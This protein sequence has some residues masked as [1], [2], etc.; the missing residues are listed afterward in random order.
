MLISSGQA[1][2]WVLAREGG[3]GVRGRSRLESSQ[4]ADPRCDGGSKA[5]GGATRLFI[6]V[7]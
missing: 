4:Q 1:W 5:D 6:V 3:A 7:L 2:G